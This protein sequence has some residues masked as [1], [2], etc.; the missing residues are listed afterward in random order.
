VALKIDEKGATLA[1]VITERVGQ[2]PGMR[3]VAFLQAWDLLRDELGRPPTVEEYAKRFTV[4][5]ATAYRDRALFEEAFPRQ[6]P[7]EVLDLLWQWHD[8]R[9][10]A[11]LGARV[12][13]EDYDEVQDW[14]AKWS[15]F[16]TGTYPPGYLDALRDE[17]ER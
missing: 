1:D 5:A 7:D 11:L 4:T 13:D 3:L 16:M 17:W 2:R 10:G 14:I 9:G 6:S 15:G 12:R 8:S